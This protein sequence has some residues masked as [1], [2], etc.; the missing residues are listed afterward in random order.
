MRSCY[1][2]HPTQFGIFSL[3][4]F[5]RLPAHPP[6]HGDDPEALLPRAA[7][8]GWGGVSVRLRWFRLSQ[9][10]T[11]GLHRYNVFCSCILEQLL[12][13]QNPWITPG[14]NSS[15]L[16]QR[17]Y[18]NIHKKTRIFNFDVRSKVFKMPFF[19]Q[20]LLGKETPC[21]MDRR[22]EIARSSTMT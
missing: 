5:I 3:K 10:E 15:S 9:R 11:Q 16:S 6:G 13:I 17:L 8:R 18:C 12:K 1:A 19:C 4:N 7:A 20:T 14:L 2:Y 22:R 21:C